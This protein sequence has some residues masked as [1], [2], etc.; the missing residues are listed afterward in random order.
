MM[1]TV[2]IVV[3]E[4]IEDIVICIEECKTTS[5]FKYLLSQKFKSGA[6]EV[7]RGENTIEFDQPFSDAD[8][9]PMIW[10]AKIADGSI[11]ENV[12]VLLTNWDANGFTLV[13]PANCT[14]YYHAIKTN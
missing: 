5:E 1:E 8:Y 9:I 4:T 6:V 2:N 10:G 7:V 12:R 3:K 14:V 13:S 11:F